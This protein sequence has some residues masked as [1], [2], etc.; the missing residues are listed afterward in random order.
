MAQTKAIIGEDLLDVEAIEVDFERKRLLEIRVTHYQTGV[1]VR[2]GE[3]RDGRGC[4][5]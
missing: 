2:G 1:R 5:M 4:R 3:T